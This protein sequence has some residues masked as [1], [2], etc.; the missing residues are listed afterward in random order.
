[1]LL[2]LRDLILRLP[3]LNLKLS[4]IINI[5]KLYTLIT[6]IAKIFLETITIFISTNK[7]N[8]AKNYLC[9]EVN[10]DLRYRINY[11]LIVSIK[12]F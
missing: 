12:V 8:D 6:K 4:K 2:Q 11:C 3:L 10:I 7:K 9:I 1:L 5:T